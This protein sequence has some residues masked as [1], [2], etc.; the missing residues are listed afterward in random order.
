MIR[1]VLLDVGNPLMFYSEK[2]QKNR[3]KSQTNGGG[4]TLNDFELIEI[5]QVDD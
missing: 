3:P 1:A 2:R 5:K 4:G